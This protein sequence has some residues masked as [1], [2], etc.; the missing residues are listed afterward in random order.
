MVHKLNPG[1]D[2]DEIYYGI[3]DG[4][5][6]PDL[7]SD[8]LNLNSNPNPVPETVVAQ[9]DTKGQIIPIWCLN[10]SKKSNPKI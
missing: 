6:T 4:S 5:P 3:V 10:F 1:P 8:P 2:P 9:P 7:N